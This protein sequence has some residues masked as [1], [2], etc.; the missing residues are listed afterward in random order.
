MKINS[1]QVLKTSDKFMLEGVAYVPSD[2]SQKVNNG[3]ILRLVVILQ[4]PR[5]LQTPA[6]D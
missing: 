3:H 6:T 1:A 2:Q 5:S 4:V